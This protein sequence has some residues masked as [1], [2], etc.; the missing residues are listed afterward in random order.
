MWCASI[1]GIE[2]LLFP[3]LFP[4]LRPRVRKLL[5]ITPETAASSYE[6]IQSI[7]ETVRELLGNGR[8]YLV[9]DRFSAADLTFACLTAPAVSP[10]EYGGSFPKLDELPSKIA[11]Q[12]KEF[13]QTPGGQFALRMFREERCLVLQ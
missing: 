8:S 6:K 1:A 2:T 7:F 9:G 12:I 10:T 13:R 3:L 4:L 11:S 5:N